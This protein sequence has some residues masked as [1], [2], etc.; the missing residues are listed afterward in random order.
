MK[1]NHTPTDVCIRRRD[2]KADKQTGDEDEGSEVSRVIVT[3]NH[4][5]NPFYSAAE[6]YDITPQ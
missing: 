3:V 1:V 4:F 2:D 6:E 5:I